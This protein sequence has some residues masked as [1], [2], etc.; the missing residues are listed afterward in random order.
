MPTLGTGVS[1][2]KGTEL[3]S[4]LVKPANEVWGAPVGWQWLPGD[5]P[6]VL[7]AKKPVSPYSGY[8][9]QLL[10]S[11]YQ[12]TEMALMHKGTVS[13]TPGVATSCQASNWSNWDGGQGV[14]GGLP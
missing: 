3:L 7:A 1:R 5:C 11:V 6:H 8:N 4:Q 2:G 12:P 9:G 14:G 13:V 10:T